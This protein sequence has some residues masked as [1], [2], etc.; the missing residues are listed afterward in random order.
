MLFVKVTRIV[1]TSFALLL[2]ALTAGVFVADI[3]FDETPTC[4]EGRAVKAIT[5]C[6]AGNKS[7]MA[8]L[9]NPAPKD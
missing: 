6:Q 9:M 7:A 5:N 3:L 8:W 1:V 2:G 4:A